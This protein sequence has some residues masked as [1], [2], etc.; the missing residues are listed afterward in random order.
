M[1]GPGSPWQVQVQESDSLLRPSPKSPALNALSSAS[2][3]HESWELAVLLC[4]LLW[5][6]LSCWCQALFWTL[7]YKT[8][9]YSFSTL[10]ELPSQPRGDSNGA[11]VMDENSA[12][13]QPLEPRGTNCFLV[14]TTNSDKV[15]RAWFLTVLR[16][17]SGV[18][19]SV[20]PSHQV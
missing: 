12:Q 20:V 16:F 14:S 6:S 7:N 17:L 19:L 9:L 4:V 8:N 11:G 5:F 2:W 3:A 10:K 18:L 1:V 13:D 15:F